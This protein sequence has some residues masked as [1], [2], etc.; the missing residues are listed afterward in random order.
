MVDFLSYGWPIDYTASTL[1]A[2]HYIIIF[3][4]ETLILSA[5]LYNIDTELSWNAITGPLEYPSFSND[6]VCSPLQTVPKRGSS[7]RRVVI[8]LS[9]LSGCSVN[10]GIPQDTYMYLD[11]YYKLQQS[12]G[13][14]GLLNSSLRKVVTVLFSRK[15]CTE[16]IVSFPL[17]RRITIYWV[18]VI[19]T[20]F[21]STFVVLLV[22]VPW[23]DTEYVGSLESVDEA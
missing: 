22:Y 23:Q 17:I 5:S 15:T 14:T 8:D 2:H 3:L 4:L 6:F 12:P 13:L 18:F 11:E 7:T 1:Q 20:N 10:D 21:I 9:F 19:R 16:L